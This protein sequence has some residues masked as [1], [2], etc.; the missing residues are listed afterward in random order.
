MKC[1]RQSP[2]KECLSYKFINIVNNE[3][4]H[5]K[6]GV[7]AL[8]FCNYK[9]TLNFYLLKQI[10]MAG[11]EAISRWVKLCNT[12]TCIH[13]ANKDIE[14]FLHKFELSLTNVRA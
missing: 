2:K 5:K 4:L 7:K 10:E 14:T 12:N 6:A 11:Q 8:A 1:K 13:K 9:Q 3:L